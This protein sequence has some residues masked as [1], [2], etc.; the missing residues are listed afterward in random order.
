[1]PMLIRG[2][3]ESKIDNDEWK[4]AFENGSLAGDADIKRL[5]EG[6]SGGAFWSVWSP[7]PKNGSDFSDEN[8]RSSKQAYNPASSMFQGS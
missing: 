3:Y 7:C 8:L 5:R 2:V 4:E 6:L 1:M